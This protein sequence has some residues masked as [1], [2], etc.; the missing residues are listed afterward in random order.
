MFRWVIQGQLARGPRPGYRGERATPAEQADVDAWIQEARGYGIRSIICL[1]GEDQLGL[2]A[3]LPTGLVSYYRQRG[4]LVEH[5]PVRDHQ[6]PPLSEDNL[7]KVLE[8]YTR[9][10]KPVLVH[11]SAGVDRTGRAIEHIKRHLEGY[12]G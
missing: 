12:R 11:C 1:L 7:Q 5:I 9:L 10:P 2:Y 3:A 6:W 4:F 8:A